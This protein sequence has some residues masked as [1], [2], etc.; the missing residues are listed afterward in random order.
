MEKKRRKQ[1]PGEDYNPR[2]KALILQVVENQIAGRDE[3]GQPIA[4]AVTEDPDYVRNTFERL[5]ASHGPAKAKEMIAAVLLEEMYDVLK[6]M[7]PF[8]EPHYKKQLER[9]R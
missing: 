8:D 4:S 3:T 9:L 7:K 1:V 5:S 6:G 2:L